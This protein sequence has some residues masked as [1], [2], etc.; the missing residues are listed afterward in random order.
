MGGGA[1]AFLFLPAF[2]A[3]FSE[4]DLLL[5]ASSAR[6]STVPCSPAVE[7][8]I[9]VSL[10]LINKSKALATWALL[11]FIVLR[12]HAM[13]FDTLIKIIGQPGGLSPTGSKGVP[14]EFGG[15][16]AVVPLFKAS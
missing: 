3:C 12:M 15:A 2:A 11:D 10:L 5:A 16:Q 4:A 8:S 7:S 1:S 9:A 6:P 13:S 14:A